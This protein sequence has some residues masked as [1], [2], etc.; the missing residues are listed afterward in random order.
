MALVR[1]ATSCGFALAYTLVVGVG[2]AASIAIRIAGSIVR[3]SAAAVTGSVFV[4]FGFVAVFIAAL[5]GV[6]GFV[7]FG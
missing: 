4:L 6:L 1:V 7:G 5:V 2:I 3:A